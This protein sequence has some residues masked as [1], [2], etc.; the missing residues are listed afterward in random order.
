[1]WLL[2]IN[3]PEPQASIAAACIFS[4]SVLQK[5]VCRVI[6][7]TTKHLNVFVKGK[8]IKATSESAPVTVSIL[9]SEKNTACLSAHRKIFLL[10]EN[11]TG[12]QTGNIKEK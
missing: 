11:L 6:D 3:S 8:K 2:L 5:I 9:V 12:S 7:T 1:M 4:M 10:Q